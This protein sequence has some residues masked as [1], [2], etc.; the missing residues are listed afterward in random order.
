MHF[1]VLTSAARPVHPMIRT[2]ELR[3][4]RETNK[5]VVIKLSS[6]MDTAI[7]MVEKK[8]DYLCCVSTPQTRSCLS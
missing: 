7:D 4:L 6:W 5:M 2:L 8:S 3:N 1:V